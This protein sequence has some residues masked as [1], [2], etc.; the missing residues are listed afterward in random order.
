MSAIGVAAAFGGMTLCG[1]VGFICG[2]QHGLVEAARQQTDRAQAERNMAIRAK[3]G[4][5]MGDDLKG[6]EHG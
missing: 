1:V 3:E 4:G 5:A 6:A 2:W